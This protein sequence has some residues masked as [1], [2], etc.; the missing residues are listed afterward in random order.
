MGFYNPTKDSKGVAEGIATLEYVQGVLAEALLI[1]G[2]TC[3]VNMMNKSKTKVYRV[4]KGA[5]AKTSNLFEDA[6]VTGESSYDDF[7]VEINKKLSAKVDGEFIPNFSDAEFDAERWN[8]LKDQFV[9][10]M[11][12][13]F[14]NLIDAIAP[15]LTV[16]G[17]N[18]VEKI[19]EAKKQIKLAS[20]KTPTTLLC[21]AD[22]IA[23]I[24]KLTFFVPNANAVGLQGEI[25]GTIKGMRVV[26][27]PLLDEMG[28]SFVPMHP[29]WVKLVL[30]N[31][32]KKCVIP[33][34]G[35]EVSNGLIIR[36]TKPEN[37]ITQSTTAHMPFGLDILKPEELG[38]VKI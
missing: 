36:T 1:P 9:I 31:P 26:E 19:I 27:H 33:G 32:T 5:V 6:T 25:V 18:T 13:N 29:K 8:I 22:A 24:E 35:D 3:E 12:T 2:V 14:M 37:N 23:D 30:I 4:V 16:T 21:S 17:V 28:I 7:E 11:N 38:V 20:K 15:V 34:F 10:Q